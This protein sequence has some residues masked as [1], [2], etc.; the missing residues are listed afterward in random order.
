MDR[1]E[2][3][4]C[5]AGDSARV[6]YGSAVLTGDG[7]SQSTNRHVM[8]ALSYGGGL[9]R[10][11]I[12]RASPI[13]ARPPPL[14]AAVLPWNRISECIAARQGERERRLEEKGSMVRHV[15]FKGGAE[16]DG[17]KGAMPC[18]RKR[19]EQIGSDMKPHTVALGEPATTAFVMEAFEITP[20]WADGA[21][22]VVGVW[23]F[24]GELPLSW[25]EEEG[26][27]EERKSRVELLRSGTN[28]SVNWRPR[29]CWV[30]QG[31]A[32]IQPAFSNNI[33]LIY[34][35]SIT[36]FVEGLLKPTKNYL[37]EIL[38]IEKG[39]YNFCYGGG[40]NWKVGE[41]RRGSNRS[42]ILSIDCPSEWKK[43]S[44]SNDSSVILSNTIETIMYGNRLRFPLK[45]DDLDAVAI[46]RKES[47]NVVSREEFNAT[48]A[49]MSH[50]LEGKCGVLGGEEFTDATYAVFEP[51]VKSKMWCSVRSFVVLKNEG[52]N[53]IKP[54]EG[55]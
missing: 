40:K 28:E 23:F 19:E 30:G 1:S 47:D 32:Q 13:A 31:Q 22:N 48:Y 43:C 51:Y 10:G 14:L 4:K 41:R 17:G 33:L 20:Q 38:S 54:L 11:W 26:E 50:I 46:K 5:G 55:K 44:I 34:S 39:G 45:R 15:S 49:F 7:E 8:A 6:H 25:F 16:G 2:M 29:L 42:V 24:L 3:N 36:T 37:F 9:H 52:S 18:V 35:N 21:M 27:H 53:L 12:R